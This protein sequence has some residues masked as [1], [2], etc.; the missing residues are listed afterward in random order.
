MAPVP[1]LWLRPCISPP[2]GE[3]LLHAGDPS[4]VC[5]AAPSCW[6]NCSAMSPPTFL[7]S[8]SQKVFNVVSLLMPRLWAL[9]RTDLSGLFSTDSAALVTITFDVAERGP[10]YLVFFFYILLPLKCLTRLLMGALLGARW[11]FP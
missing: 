9:G 2:L 5:G 3:M 10:R 8:S 11:G 7:G 4:V 1:P 6:N